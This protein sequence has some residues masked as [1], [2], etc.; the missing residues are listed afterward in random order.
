M[1]QGK[2]ERWYTKRSV[3]GRYDTS[4]KTI[5]RWVKAGRF[6]KPTRMGNGRDYW[7]DTTLEEFEKSL[8]AGE[9]VA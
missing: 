8:V 9:K 2:I 7:A 5:E 6:P 1:S 4:M 3:A